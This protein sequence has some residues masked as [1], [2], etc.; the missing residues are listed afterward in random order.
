[1]I[2]GKLL[3]EADAAQLRS[4]C[5]AA[6]VRTGPGVQFLL[7]VKDPIPA[8]AKACGISEA[9]GRKLAA[10]LKGAKATQPA[11]DPRHAGIRQRLQSLTNRAKQ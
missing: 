4:V 10:Q 11:E 9:Q 5:A 1:M 2:A 6:G 3:P 8:L 7:A